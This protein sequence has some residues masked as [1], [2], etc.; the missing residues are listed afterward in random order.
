MARKPIPDNTINSVLATIPMAIQARLAEKGPG[1]FASRHE[2]QGVLDEEFHE[3]REAL[4]S[5]IEKDY[6]KELMDI[7]VGAVFGMACMVEGTMDW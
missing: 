3:L 7:A 4:Q 2:I 6:Y 1:T 5:N